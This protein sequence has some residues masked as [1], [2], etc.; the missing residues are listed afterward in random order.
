LAAFAGPK[1]PPGTLGLREAVQVLG[2]VVISGPLVFALISLGL[3]P[4][5]GEGAS[6]SFWAFVT[7]VYYGLPLLAIRLVS[8]G[9]PGGL[10]AAVGLRNT[11]AQWLAG[12]ALLGAIVTV[13][14]NTAYSA[15]M[16]LA[17]LG[18]PEASM[19]VMELLTGAPGDSGVERLVSVVL[20]VVI[21]PLAEEMIFRGVVLSGVMRRVGPV[22]GIL[23]TAAVFAAVHLDLWRFVPLAFLGI[24]LGYLAWQSRSVWPAV[25]A[26]ALVN[27]FAYVVALA[28]RAG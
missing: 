25:V 5:L 26:H 6:T 22:P 24:V 4:D 28:S 21:A 27:G 1:T 23:V 19:R 2:A 16:S 9:E 12:A 15:W 20:V 18:P 10:G 11:S 14:F 3:L 17:G 13:A 8:V 7:V